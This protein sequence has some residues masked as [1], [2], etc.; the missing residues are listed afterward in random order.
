VSYEGRERR[1]RPEL[2]EP[3][4]VALP[5][6][7]QPVVAHA[8]RGTPERRTAVAALADGSLS[9]A[10]VQVAVNDFTGERS[11][12]VQLTRLEGGSP[13]QLLLIDPTQTLLYGWSADGRLGVWELEPEPRAAESHPLDRPVSAMALLLGGRS[14]LLGHADG[15]L[16]QYFRVPYGEAR[17]ELTRV[18]SFHPLGSGV[19]QLVSSQRDRSFLARAGSELGLYHAT[20]GRRL[21][22]GG[23]G[24]VTSGPLEWGPRG[25]RVY[26]AGADGISVLQVENP[27][28][29]ASL[30]TY[31]RPVWYEDYPAPALVWQSTGGTD[32]FEPKLSLTPLLI[33]TLKGT[34]YALLVAMPLG[35]LGAIYVSQFMHPRLQGIVK[36]TVELMASL[37]SVVLG[38][39]AG[40]WLAPRLE[41]WL[42]GVLALALVLPLLSLVA[43][44]LWQALPRRWTGRLLEGSELGLYAVVLALGAALCLQLSPWLELR[45]FGDSAP[46]WLRQHT[47]LVY[48]QRNALVAGIAMGFAVIPIVLSLTE[49]ALSNVPASLTAGSLALGASRWQ[50]VARIVLPAAA[51]GIFAA[52]MIGLGRAIGETM[53]VLMATGN[54]PILDWS[55]FSGFR[56]L[57]ANIAVEIP[58]A[59]H[60]QTLYRTLFLS[61]LLLFALTFALNTA[62]ELV[63]ERLRGRLAGK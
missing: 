43:G 4:S 28:P 52:L 48:D 12:Q 24:V 51:P 13:V 58:E 37:P 20:S 21:W 39:V 47:G 23:A 42:P 30:G 45:L 1:V 26:A 60:G 27:H 22:A 62:A 31:V 34:L 18:R 54:T 11:E 57:S 33:G 29:E 10:R 38:F 55:P 17:V 59:P 50:T 8:A 44:A 16:D 56:T 46:T 15:S 6:D 35:I 19:S 63:R 25:Q 9:I 41:R 49:D 7:G 14:L 3:W 40:L 2:G 32:S 53:I 5:T 61:A 36:P